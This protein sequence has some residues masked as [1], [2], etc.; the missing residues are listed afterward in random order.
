MRQAQ[1]P[2][3]LGRHVPEH[4]TPLVRIQPE[5]VVGRERVLQA[6]VDRFALGLER[7]EEAIPH[8]EDPR[9]VAVEVLRVGA[10]VDAVVAG[11]LPAD[12]WVPVRLP[13]G[14]LAVKVAADLSNVWMR[15]PV[16]HVFDGT[17]P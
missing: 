1:A 17:L 7:A 10:V 12:A 16:R 2:G 11:E 4:R 3:L 6:V 5:Q 15:G 14:A 13:G 9:V 8:D